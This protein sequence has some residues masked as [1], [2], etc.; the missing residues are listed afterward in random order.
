MTIKDQPD[1]IVTDSK[2]IHDMVIE[3]MLERK[4]IG[5]DRYGTVLQHDNGRDHVIDSYQEALDLCCYLRA[6]I[7]RRKFT[8][9]ESKVKELGYGC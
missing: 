2:S 9:I 7:E 4:Q 8:E 6:E 3:D 1:P 5:L